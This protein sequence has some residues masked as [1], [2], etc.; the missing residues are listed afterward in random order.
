[1]ISL[2]MQI[3]NVSVGGVILIPY[4]RQIN[5]KEMIKMGVIFIITGLIGVGLLIYLFYILFRGEKL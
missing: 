3:I 2:E 1:M 4:N 5:E